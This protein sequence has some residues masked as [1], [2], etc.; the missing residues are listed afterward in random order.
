MNAPL[1][2]CP[3]MV[4][5]ISRLVDGNLGRFMT[6]FIKS[7]TDKCP[8]CKATYKAMLS[9]REGLRKAGR[10]STASNLLSE[11]Q[12]R[13]IEEACGAQT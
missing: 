5:P 7:H 9:L 10:E 13:K 4:K 2:P 3:G 1:N 11:D 12:W 8:K 6:W